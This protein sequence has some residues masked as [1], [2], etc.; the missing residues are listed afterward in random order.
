MNGIGSSCGASGSSARTP[1]PDSRRADAAAAR[2]RSGEAAALEVT[3]ADGDTVRISFS[4]ASRLQAGSRSLSG[5]S[6]VQ[7]RV[8]VQGTLDD[9]ETSQIGDLLERLVTAARGNAPVASAPGESGSLGHFQFAY[10]AYQRMSLA[11]SDPFT[12]PTGR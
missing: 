4:A 5:G 12:A 8:D 9:T 7:V 11:A 2:F 1:A 10:R 3:T 6:A